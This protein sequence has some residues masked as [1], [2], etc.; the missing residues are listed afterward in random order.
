MI[1]ERTFLVVAL[2]VAA[3]LVHTA[4]GSAQENRRVPTYCGDVQPIL[5]KHCQNCHRPGEM[6]FPL[7][8]YGQAARRAQ[9]IEQ[10][11]ISKKCRRGLPIRHTAISRTIRR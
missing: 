8:S 11:V 4:P 10:S 7:V 1:S 5:E 6:A 3:L 9:S 2:G